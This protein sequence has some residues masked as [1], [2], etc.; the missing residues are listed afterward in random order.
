LICSSELGLSV[1]E[2]LEHSG[3]NGLA[4]VKSPLALYHLPQPSPTQS[5]FI[6]FFQVL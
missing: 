3:A 4:D 1:M 6:T 2:I 5:L